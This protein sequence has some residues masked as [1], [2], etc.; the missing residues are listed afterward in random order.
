MLRGRSIWR[1]I[2]LRESVE[3]I[4]GPDLYEFVENSPNVYY[5]K[6]GLLLGSILIILETHACPHLGSNGCKA[7]CALIYQAQLIADATESAGITAGSGGLAIAIGV[8]DFVLS[9]IADADALKAC[10]DGC[11]CKN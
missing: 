3:T 4:E 11:P 7:C 8:T 10:I 6:N 2:L 9:N 5:D 1:N